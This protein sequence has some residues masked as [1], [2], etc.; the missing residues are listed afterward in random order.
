[1]TCR[2]GAFTGRVTG[3]AQL[4]LHRLYLPLLR[5]ASTSG[6][7]IYRSP[8]PPPGQPNYTGGAV[9]KPPI[10]VFE[11][12]GK[13]AKVGAYSQSGPKQSQLQPEC[14]PATREVNISCTERAQRHS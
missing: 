11:V 3:V 2:S 12:D 14:L 10:S 7:E 9:T 1:M 8:P 5:P 6:D 13:K 4:R